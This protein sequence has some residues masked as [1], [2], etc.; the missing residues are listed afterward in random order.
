MIPFI[1]YSRNDITIAIKKKQQQ[2]QQQ[3]TDRWLLG[4]GDGGRG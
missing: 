4:D 3:K 2:Q 1:S